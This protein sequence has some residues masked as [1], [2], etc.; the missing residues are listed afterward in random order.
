MAV[1]GQKFLVYHPVISKLSNRQSTAANSRPC[2]GVR[3]DT[4]AGEHSKYE[5]EARGQLGPAPSG[6]FNLNK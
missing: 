4:P 6:K 1:P 5:G 2:W 3:Y